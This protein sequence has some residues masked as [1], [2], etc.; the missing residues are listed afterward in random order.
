MRLIATLLSLLIL[1]TACSQEPPA[2]PVDADADGTLVITIR[3]GATGKPITDAHY[4]GMRFAAEEHLVESSPHR[5]VDFF[6]KF[7]SV[8]GVSRWELPAGWHKLRIEAD[9]YWRAW[10]PIFRIEAGKETEL[11]FEMHQN[12]LL[13]IKVFDADGSPLKEGVIRVEMGSLLG[14]VDIKDGSGELWVED[15]EVTLG[16]GRIWLKEY[17][18]QSITVALTPGKVNEAT[19]HLTK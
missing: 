13:K 11:T 4:Y 5:E 3:D 17:K 10:T 16:V 18:E 6:E 7:H 14:S 8:D 12:I 1:T 15:D 9:D 19:I 2:D